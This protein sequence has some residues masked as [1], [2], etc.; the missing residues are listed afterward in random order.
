MWKPGQIVTIR[1][2]KYR[3]KKSSHRL[4]IVDREMICSIWKNYNHGSSE[5]SIP[6]L[7]FELCFSK[8]PEAKLSD[9]LYL[10]E[11]K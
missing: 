8:F 11:I 4:N 5:G 9:D 1:G 7:C 3:V 6:Y 10:K 2:K